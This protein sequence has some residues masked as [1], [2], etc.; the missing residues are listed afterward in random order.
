[1]LLFVRN[2]YYRDILSGAKRF[3]MRCGPRYRNLAPGA[4]A[5]KPEPLKAA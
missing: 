2:P 4:A 1:M 5:P 3:E